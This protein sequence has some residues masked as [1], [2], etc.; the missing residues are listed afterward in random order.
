MFFI[1]A[2][3]LSAALSPSPR[4]SVSRRAVL[5]G[6]GAT[7]L[8][9]QRPA[10]ADDLVG[11]AQ[12]ALFEIGDAGKSTRAIA[13]EEMKKIGADR[14]ERLR[15][16]ALPISRLRV[17]RSDLDTASALLEKNDWFALRGLIA[18]NVGSGDLGNVRALTKEVNPALK[19][20]R[21][22][23][24]AALAEVD[25]FAY[26]RQMYFAKTSGAIGEFGVDAPVV[27]LTAPA[28]ALET[29]KRALDPF[30]K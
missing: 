15:I 6:L 7:A 29:G 26:G 17:A 4:P 16:A 11:D 21:A 13:Q 28:A 2:V 1:T 14:K 10:V 19:A 5:G 24:L 25:K 9:L 18:G 22:T 27:D 8:G 30:V 3:A 20:E 12:D 23:L